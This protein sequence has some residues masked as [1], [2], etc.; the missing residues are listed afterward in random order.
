ME[1]NHS[2]TEPLSDE[3]LAV[4]IQQGQ[5]DYFGTLIERYEGKLL[6][7]GTKFLSD[8]NDIE[9]LVHDAFLNA[10]KNMRVF[11]PD[12]RFSPWMYRIAHN[13][14]VNA[15]RSAGKL[16]LFSIDLDTF[17][18]P[19]GAESAENRED[20][21]LIHEAITKGLQALK[22]KY[23]EVL[24]LHYFEEMPYKEIAD[25]LHIPIGT[26]SVRIL[27]A[28]KALREVLDPATL[29]GIL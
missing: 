17:V 25:V 21:Q 18:A 16:P 11:D 8:R 29:P 23:R 26:V 3:A 2:N 22:P 28:K 10:Y 24:I 4:L 13:T 19:I 12:L 27:R 15:L 6:R 1:K 14:F 20:Q 7:Y 9:D 5:T